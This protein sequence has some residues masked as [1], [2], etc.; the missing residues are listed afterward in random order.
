MSSQGGRPQHTAALPYNGAA[1]N[2]TA[3]GA[4]GN[5]A[6]ISIGYG[7]DTDSIR[8]AGDWIK[9]K[10][11]LLVFNENKSKSFEDPWFVRGN[12][13]RLTWMLGRSKQPA[14]SPCV[15]CASGSAFV[16]NGPF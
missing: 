13:Y 3:V 15:V 7:F 8:D 2:N 16:G 14:S 5:A 10:K 1:L 6:A 12:D 11:Q 4:A 9:Y